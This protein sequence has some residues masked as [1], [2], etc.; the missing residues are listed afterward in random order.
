MSQPGSL[1]VIMLVTCVVSVLGI[2]LA[3][4]PRKQTRASEAEGLASRAGTQRFLA[5]N[6]AM[7]EQT[8]RDAGMSED[9]IADVRAKVLGLGDDSTQ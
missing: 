1:L 3:G 8:A 7:V 4:R 9:E 2:L 5:E 6:W